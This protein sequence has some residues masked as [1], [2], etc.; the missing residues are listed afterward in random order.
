[1]AKPVR[2]LLLLL[3]TESGVG[4][5]QGAP[6]RAVR[7]SQGLR[8]HSV[9][10]YV[11]ECIEMSVVALYIFDLALPRWVLVHKLHNSRNQAR[12]WRE[13]SSAP[14][15]RRRSSSTPEENYKP[16]TYASFT[17]LPC[18]RS[19]GIVTSHAASWRPGAMP[20][21]E[22]TIVLWLCHSPI[23]SRRMRSRRVC[24][25]GRAALLNRSGS[26]GSK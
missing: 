21:A 25:A 15:K 19:Q 13:R 22:L 18:P 23:E 1:M 16:C 5:T 12:D 17:V 3:P 11:S 6:S 26:K 2:M 7:A 9:L 20:I 24:A 14:M 4:W 8:K 10:L